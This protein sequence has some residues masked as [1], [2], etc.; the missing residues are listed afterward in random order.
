MLSQWSNQ[1][2]EFV[3]ETRILAEMKIENPGIKSVSWEKNQQ[4]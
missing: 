4:A 2:L 1:S 3:V